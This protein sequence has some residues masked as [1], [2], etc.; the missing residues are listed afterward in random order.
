MTLPLAR[1]ERH[2]L[3]DLALT[4]GEDAPTLCGDWTVKDL[5][6]HLLV[7]ENRPWAAAGI[8]VPRLS[9]LTEKSMVRM[10]RNDFGVLVEK[11]RDP[12]LTVYRLPP[13]EVAFNTLEYFV[14]HEDIRR[15]TSGW[16][17]RDLD[18]DD[19]DL[20]WK[21]GRGSG[22]LMARRIGR[23][24]RIRRSD[25]GAEATLSSGDDPVVVSGPP[26]EVV[27]FLFGRD[28]VRDLDFEGPPEGVA[29]VR[30]ADLG[31]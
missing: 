14:H 1:R 8:V 12:G 22:R 18:P 30:D 29:R 16:K 27:L 4:V 9:G 13:A 24:F 23:P 10:T 6:A 28:Q 2:E 5:V 17:P 20:I 19:V 21:L 31:F 7:R 3:C 25:T 26:G 11:L 15:A